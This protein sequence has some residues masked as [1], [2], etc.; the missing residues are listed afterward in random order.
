LAAA[1]AK[2]A[3]LNYNVRA[4]CEWAKLKVSQLQALGES[5]TDLRSHMFKAFLSSNDK[6]L[7]S[8]VKQQKDFVRDNPTVPYDYKVLMARVKD[9]YDSI[10][11]DLLKAKVAAP[12][13]DSIVA[14]EAEIRQQKKMINKLAKH[15]KRDNKKG[16]GKGG[17]HKQD[18]KSKGKKD[19]VPFPD[20]LKK[21]PA[22]AD[23]SKP[24]IID[25]HSYWFCTEHKKWGRHSSK[26]CKKKGEGTSSGS[27]KDD[28]KYN[29][30]LVR[31][32][33]ALQ[34]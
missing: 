8:Y 18:K 3:A 24:A 28:G 25:G 26:D 30:R 27:K 23:P 10:E 12:P 6:E 9:K 21:K 14:L 32:L 20:E 22:P 17:D 16:G 1:D 11:Q 29:G 7:V 15:G 33:A 31:A 2:F 13:E 19:F 4:L 34:E 5:T